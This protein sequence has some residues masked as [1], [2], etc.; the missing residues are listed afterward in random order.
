MPLL[1]APTDEGR[2]SFRDHGRRCSG[3]SI[4]MNGAST[5]RSTFD[6]ARPCVD[7][8]VRS[9]VINSVRVASRDSL[10]RAVVQP[11]G[12]QS[13]EEKRGA[14][15]RRLPKFSNFSAAYQMRA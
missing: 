12:A 13:L 5:T 7:E 8:L 2:E 9:R 10:Y 3:F 1:H 6:E 11:C 4:S 15:Q 14:A